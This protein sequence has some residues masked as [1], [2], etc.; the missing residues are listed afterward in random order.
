MTIT[1]VWNMKPC[2]QAEIYEHVRRNRRLHAE[3]E[4]REEGRGRS[5]LLQN[6][7]TFYDIAIRHIL[8]WG[9]KIRLKF[10]LAKC[11]SCI[12]FWQKDIKMKGTF[13]DKY[14]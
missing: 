12:K 10:A 11:G 4:E 6:D 3:G 1:V 13:W 5:R 8:E 7:G 2:S 14:V 9:L